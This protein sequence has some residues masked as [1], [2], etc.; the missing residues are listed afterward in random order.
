M[1]MFVVILASQI[2]DLIAWDWDHFA[3]LSRRL[4]QVRDWALL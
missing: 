2:A 4:D 3:V 1:D